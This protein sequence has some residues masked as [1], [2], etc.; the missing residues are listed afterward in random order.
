[1]H[2]YTKFWRSIEL[3]LSY[4]NLTVFQNGGR[5]PSCI[6]KIQNFYSLQRRDGQN[7]DFMKLEG[8]IAELW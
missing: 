3:L 5:L 8:T 4:G 6:F 1:M 2:N 7:M